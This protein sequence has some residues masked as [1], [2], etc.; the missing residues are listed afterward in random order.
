LV[1]LKYQFPIFNH[2]ILKFI[3]Y[4]Q[5]PFVFTP[6]YS[7][8][9]LKFLVILLIIVLLIGLHYY[10][11]VP[12]SL[13]LWLPSHSLHLI[14]PPPIVAIILYYYSNLNFIP[15]FLYSNFT[16]NLIFTPISLNFHFT[17]NLIFL[18]LHIQFS[19]YFQFFPNFH[20]YPILIPPNSHSILNC[21]FLPNSHFSLNLLII[22]LNPHLHHRFTSLPHSRPL[23][24][25]LVFRVP[26]PH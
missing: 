1:I 13:G 22:H 3:F 14:S 19:Q 17:M 9:I 18:S 20:F 16:P 6:I 23:S 5:I 8:V 15:I 4:L 10:L 12:P 24:T 21:P 7:I 2:N 25:P 26:V 11:K